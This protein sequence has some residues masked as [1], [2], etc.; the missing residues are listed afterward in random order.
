MG[1]DR[2]ADAEMKQHRV[3]V[4]ETESKKSVVAHAKLGKALVK[5]PGSGEEKL[6]ES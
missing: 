1:D 2:S 5:R 4:S 3:V 6:I